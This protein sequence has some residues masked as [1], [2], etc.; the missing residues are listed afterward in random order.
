MKIFRKM[1]SPSAVPLLC[2]APRTVLRI[3]NRRAVWHL[4]SLQLQT[5]HAKYQ[6]FHR[7]PGFG[8]N[9]LVSGKKKNPVF[10]EW[11]QALALVNWVFIFICSATT[12]QIK[13]LISC[14]QMGTWTKPWSKCGF[15]AKQFWLICHNK[16]N[17]P[18]RTATGKENR[19]RKCVFHCI[20]L[21]S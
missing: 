4:P 13:M 16:C 1:W 15:S 17:C 7:C 6:E 12:V 14:M 21:N 18:F 10:C 11:K 5:S 20:M 8:S 9:H 2:K 3:G 19:N